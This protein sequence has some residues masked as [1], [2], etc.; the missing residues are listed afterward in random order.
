MLY[1]SQAFDFRV[2]HII[3]DPWLSAIHIVKWR[4]TLFDM[5]GKTTI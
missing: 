4:F 2:T 5:S 1:F 3:S